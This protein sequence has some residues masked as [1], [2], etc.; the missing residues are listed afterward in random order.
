MKKAILPIM[1]AIAL[2]FTFSS[3]EH[4][5][6]R[7]T[8]VTIMP[9][10]WVTNSNVNY[11][12]ATVRW[13]ELDA[14]VVDYGIV[15]AYL[16]NTLTGVQDMLPLVTP[17]T[18]FNVDFDGDGIVDYST[19]TTPENIRF[20]IRYGEIT[21]IIQDQDGGMPLDMDKTQPMT[22]RIVAIGD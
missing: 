16:V 20:D 4:Q 13:D 10:E 1:A 17:M 12:Y 5:S 7:A 14:D 19:Y 8:E 2:A 3:C 18:Y 11:Y 21:F 22:F 9:G 15:N 6:M